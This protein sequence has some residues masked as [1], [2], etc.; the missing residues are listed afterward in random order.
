[1]LT[2]TPLGLVTLVVAANVKVPF[3]SPRM[4]MPA[5]PPPSAVVPLKL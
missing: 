1:M 2:P 3:E 4:S 5:S